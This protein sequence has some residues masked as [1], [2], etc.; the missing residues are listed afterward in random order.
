MTNF[1]HTW[2]LVLLL[3]LEWGD[4]LP[5]G[6]PSYLKEIHSG[7]KLDVLWLPWSGFASTNATLEGNPTWGTK[8]N[9]LYVIWFHVV[10]NGLVRDVHAMLLLLIIIIIIEDYRMLEREE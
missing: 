10:I 8:G 3:L 4:G 1:A 5:L 2:L 6:L 9:I 7:S